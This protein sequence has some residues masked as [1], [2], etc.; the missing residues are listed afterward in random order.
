V[1]DTTNR[2][3]HDPNVAP[4]P[5]AHQQ[6]PHRSVAWATSG[7]DAERFDPD[8][9]Q[10]VPK[11][12]YFDRVHRQMVP[13]GM[14]WDS[15][16]NAAVHPERRGGHGNGGMAGRRIGGRAVNSRY[17]PRNIRAAQRAVEAV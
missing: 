7:F 3:A 13:R 12:H 8:A 17:K 16:K 5:E 10:V 1:K 6:P 9:G 2:N 14:V 4:V 11:G 15:E